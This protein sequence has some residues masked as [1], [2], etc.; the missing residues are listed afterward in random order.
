M[1]KTKIVNSSNRPTTIT[2]DNKYFAEGSKN[3]KLKAGPTF[4]TPGP[5][6]PRHVPAAPAAV[7]KSYSNSVKTPIYVSKSLEQQFLY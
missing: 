1:N 3:E 6:L 7:S 2:K 5:T 4:P